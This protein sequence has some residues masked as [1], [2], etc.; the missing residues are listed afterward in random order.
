MSIAQRLEPEEASH[1]R[2]ELPTAYSA[3]RNDLEQKIV[4][5]WQELMGIQDVGIFDNYFDLGGDSLLAG[6][7]IHRIRERFDVEVPLDKFFESAT[8]AALADRVGSI[9]WLK[10]NRSK[11]SNGARKEYGEI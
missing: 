8:V 1:A 11:A 7:L 10:Q 9:L 5:I 2:P 4:G 6:Q 3:P